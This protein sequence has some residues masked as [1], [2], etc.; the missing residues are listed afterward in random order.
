[1]RD[2]EPEPFPPRLIILTP[3]DQEC[4]V[5]PPPHPQFITRERARSVLAAAATLVASLSAAPVCP[6]VCVCVSLRVG[7]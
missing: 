4:Q 3:E 2:V 1:M 5:K 6:C 7:V